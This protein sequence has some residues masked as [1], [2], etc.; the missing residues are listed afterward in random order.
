MEMLRNRK[1]TAVVNTRIS[2]P[3]VYFFVT[4]TL[5]T[6]SS[7]VRVYNAAAMTGTIE[8]DG[9]RFPDSSF[10]LLFRLKIQL[11][12]RRRETSTSLPKAILDA[13]MV[14]LLKRRP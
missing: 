6:H 3:K 4:V 13:M 1:R 14:M 10:F 5:I 11:V 7:R 2:I 8:R 9:T 12:R